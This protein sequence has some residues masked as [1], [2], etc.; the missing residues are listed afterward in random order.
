VRELLGFFSAL[1]LKLGVSSE[2]HRDLSQRVNTG[3]E[4]LSSPRQANGVTG[5]RDL[6]TDP[7]D[8]PLA[9]RQPPE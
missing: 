7:D 9:G 8:L 1:A 2:Q 4:A 5:V 6:W 3:I